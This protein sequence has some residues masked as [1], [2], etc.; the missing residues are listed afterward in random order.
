MA[1]RIEVNPVA[2]WKREIFAV[3]FYLA[4][5]VLALRLLGNEVHGVTQKC[6]D[7]LVL[8]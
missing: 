1:S 6:S 3:Y 8:S 2:L 7:N 5:K 4:C